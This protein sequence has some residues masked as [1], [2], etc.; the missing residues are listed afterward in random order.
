MAIDSTTGLPPGGDLPVNPAAERSLGQ[1]VAQATQ[2]M[3]EIVRAEM[4]LAKAEITSDVRNGAMA[5]GLFGAAGYVVVLATILLSIAAGYGLVAAGLAPWLAFLVLGCV[6]LLLAV[7]LALVGKSR[8]S[9][10]GPPERAIRSARQ[11]LAAVKP[12]SRDR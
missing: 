12:G 6:Y 3:T 10:V 9:R 11:T 4:A 2:D 5:G 7:L 1:L 8:V